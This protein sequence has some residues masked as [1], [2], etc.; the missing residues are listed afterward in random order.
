GDLVAGGRVVVHDIG[1]VLQ[2][3]EQ[4]LRRLGVLRDCVGTH[5][6][7][8]FP[9]VAAGDLFPTLRAVEDNVPVRVL[10]GADARERLDHERGIDTA[11]FELC[12]RHG[13]V[14]IHGNDVFAEIDALGVGIDL[15]YLELRSAH[16]DGQL[17][18]LEIG[19]GLDLLVLGE[20]HKVSEREAGA[21][22]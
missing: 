3:S 8:D 21:D 13:K 11:S 20:D 9:A 17:F 18:A 10:F 12:A 15:R 7:H 16:V 6:V 22:D 14:R 1:N 19:Q 5:S 2:G 4:H